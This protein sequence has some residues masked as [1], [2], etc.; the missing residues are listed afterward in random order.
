MSLV[1]GGS[2][3]VKVVSATNVDRCVK[4][5]GGLLMGPRRVPEKCTRFR[6]ERGR[7]T[8]P[9]ATELFMSVKGATL[10]GN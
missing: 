2:I 1:V 8:A 3:G 4:R 9:T 6:N 5:A 10:L 7:D